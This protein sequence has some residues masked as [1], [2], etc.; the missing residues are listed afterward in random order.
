MTLDPDTH[1]LVW[2][3]RREH[4][5]PQEFALAALLF[6]QPGKLVSHGRIFAELYVD[7]IDGGPLWFR[8]LVRVLIYHLRRK[9]KVIGWPGSINSIASVGYR[10]APPDRA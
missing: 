5:S 8:A 7:P 10:V 1:E 9:L 6:A 4:L 3:G 2:R